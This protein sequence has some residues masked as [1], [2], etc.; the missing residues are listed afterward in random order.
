MRC[1]DNHPALAPQLAD[2]K[3]HLRRRA[4]RIKQIS[5]NP[6]RREN[7]SRRL[8]ILARMVAA[9]MPDAHSFLSLREHPVDII[10]KPLGRRPHRIAVHAVCPHAHNASQASRPKLQIIIK[11]IHQLRTVRCIHHAPCLFPG[12]PVVCL[13][14]P[15]LCLRPG[16][17]NNFL[18]FHKS[19]RLILLPQRYK[20]KPRICEAFRRIYDLF[21]LILAFLPVRLRK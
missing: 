10:G 15:S 3:R 1:R 20:K 14:Q 17:L 13:A 7:G 21:S 11:R 8:R 4:Q 16:Y 5:R 6:V 19:F 12:L 18:V 2:G 9:V